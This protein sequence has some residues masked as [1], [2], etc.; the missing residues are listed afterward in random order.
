VH[1]H[2]GIPEVVAVVMVAVVRLIA[3]AIDDRDRWH[4]FLF[5]VFLALAVV[6]IWWVLADGGVH[7]LVHDFGGT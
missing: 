7:V 2:I 3:F 4:R 1:P 5:L 6:V